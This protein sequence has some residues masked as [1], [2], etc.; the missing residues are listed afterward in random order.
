VLAVV[1]HHV[2]GRVALPVLAQ[3]HAHHPLN[4]FT[5]VAWSST[6]NIT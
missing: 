4:N 1:G 6:N 3:H 2:V 5:T